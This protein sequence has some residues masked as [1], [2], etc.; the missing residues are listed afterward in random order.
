M[1]SIAGFE[2]TNELRKQNRLK[3]YETNYALIAESMVKSDVA[4]IVNGH[5]VY[6]VYS[7]SVN[8]A[9]GPTTS[10]DAIDL[11][12]S[13]KEEFDNFK[14]D[15]DDTNT[16][17]YYKNNPIDF[18]QKYPNVS[19]KTGHYLNLVDI[20]DTQVAM[21][22]SSQDSGVHTYHRWEQAFG[23]SYDKFGKTELAS[24]TIAEYK[25]QLQSYIDS[26]KNAP[27]I[28]KQ[29]LAKLNDRKSK[30]TNV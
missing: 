15:A 10:S 14:L 17:E 3:D 20:S 5:P 11:F 21:S 12:Y 2:R 8:L 24:M 28:Y 19:S 29:E 13:E 16:K 25:Q 23:T 30:L 4:F 18:Y 22:L 6:S 27:E 9:W 26:L 7:S 1:A